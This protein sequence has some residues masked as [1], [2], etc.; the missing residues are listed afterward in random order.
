MESRD[1]RGYMNI[2]SRLNG[3]IE[4]YYTSGTDESN[5]PPFIRYTFDLINFYKSKESSIPTKELNKI[6]RKLE[7]I[8]NILDPIIALDPWNNL[9]KLKK[10]NIDYKLGVADKEEAVPIEDMS[11]VYLR[12]GELTKTKMSRELSAE[13]MQFRKKSSTHESL[14]EQEELEQLKSTLMEYE[15][16]ARYHNNL[17]ALKAKIN[18][19]I[20]NIH[21]GKDAFSHEVPEYIRYSL[22][23]INYYEN[24]Q[25]R[26][27]LTNDQY[28]DM[29]TKFQALVTLLDNYEKHQKTDLLSAA[30]PKEFRA[31]ALSLEDEKK[32]FDSFRE[33]LLR[34]YIN[35]RQVTGEFDDEEEEKQEVYQ[36]ELYKLTL[37]RLNETTKL[38]GTTPE[39]EEEKEAL[40]IQYD[41][42]ISYAY[43]SGTSVSYILS[44][45]QNKLDGLVQK[46]ANSLTEFDEKVAK[47]DSRKSAFKPIHKKTLGRIKTLKDNKKHGVGVEK[48]T[49]GLWLIEESLNDPKNAEK[50]SDLKTYLSSLPDT[51]MEAEYNEALML[52]RGKL[53][54]LAQKQGLHLFRSKDDET[55]LA[56]K[57]VLRQIKK[58]KNKGKVS[59]T[60]LTEG[61]NLA[62]AFLELPDE[63]NRKNL[64]KYANKLPKDKPLSLAYKILIAAVCFTIIT[65]ALVVLCLYFP[66]AT[67]IAIPI[68]MKIST[69][70]T[71]IFAS[72]SSLVGGSWFTIPKIPTLAWGLT[73]G[74]L[75]GILIT[76]T[77]AYLAI[78][79]NLSSKT[80]HDSINEAKVHNE[81]ATSREEMDE[82]DEEEEEDYC[83]DDDEEEEEEEEVLH[84]EDALN[85]LRLSEQRR[86]PSRTGMFGQGRDLPPRDEQ[87]NPRP[88]IQGKSNL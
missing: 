46:A 68:L 44:Q 86:Q 76:A 42:R 9:K 34:Q 39:L 52:L 54:Y 72:V 74:A 23:L 69:M 38:H 28:D 13:F 22:Y 3:Q 41:N 87:R 19:C 82:D 51:S 48:L 31:I 37:A 67:A 40:I 63:N 77:V 30:T 24:K 79:S 15:S 14:S 62:Y 75:A 2:L 36:E 45:I 85:F 55:M 33:K 18:S 53:G 70:A 8:Y 10:M 58:V 81:D 78:K 47:L 49:Y 4:V 61:L 66:P 17:L 25:Q 57:K 84:L 6:I 60:E 56:A 32:E 27:D 5:I 71:S 80:I 16:I 88:K 7:A 65:A 29:S 20:E 1:T 12:I 11:Q 59:L 43:R 35:A 83:S 73:I 50:L 21:A 26:L 64:E